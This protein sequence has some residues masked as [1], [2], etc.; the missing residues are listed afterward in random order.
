M[1]TRRRLLMFPA[2]LGYMKISEFSLGIDRI[3]NWFNAGPVSVTIKTEFPRP[4][5]RAEFDLDQSEFLDINRMM[6]VNESFFKDG[7]IRKL[8]DLSMA[9]TSSV[10]NIEFDSYSSYLSWDKANKP[11]LNKSALSRLNY[12]IDIS[13]EPI[14]RV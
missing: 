1:I 11:L 5:T 4:L 8:T 14:V 10:W 7:K 12:K 13:V 9:N 3:S 6:A 2:A